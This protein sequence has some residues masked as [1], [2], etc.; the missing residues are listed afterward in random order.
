MMRKRGIAI[1]TTTSTTMYSVIVFS[2]ALAFSEAI[3]TP[4]NTGKEE[5]EEEEEK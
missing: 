5:E 3:A 1:P 4:H 2:G